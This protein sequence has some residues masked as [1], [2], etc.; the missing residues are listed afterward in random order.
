MWRKSSSFLYL[1]GKPG[2]SEHKYN[3][4]LLRDV[5][6]IKKAATPGFDPDIL[7]EEL[8]RIINWESKRKSSLVLFIYL[9]FVWHFQPWM[10][11][12]VLLLPFIYNLALQSVTG[13]KGPSSS[14]RDVARKD[15]EEDYPEEEEEFSAVAEAKTDEIKRMS[16]K[17]RML[18]VEEISLT[19]Q[20]WLGTGAHLLESLQNL[21]DFSVPF[22]S[23]L[24]V[25][26]IILA[27]LLLLLVPLRL[28]IML[29]GAEKL[30]KRL[31]NPEAEFNNEIG[32]LLSRVPDHEQMKESSHITTKNNALH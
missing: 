23:W 15:S 7:L 18:V 13:L 1:I 8:T 32:N 27:T 3:R 16:L 21:A 12:F 25:A 29:W 31:F 2:F 11:T 30:T 22:L 20:D 10:L 6:R 4:F 14:G 5:S 9:L 28:L 17:K 19:I 24:T 26:G